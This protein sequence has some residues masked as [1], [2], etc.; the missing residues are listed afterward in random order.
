MMRQA[1]TRWILLLA[2]A[3]LAASAMPTL[4]QQDKPAKRIGFLSV[5]S[6]QGREADLNAFRAG[7]TELRWNEG[8]DYVLS[9]RWANGDTSA[10]PRLAAEL[11]AEKSDLLLA[12]S[13]EASRQFAQ[14]TKTLPILFVVAQDPVGSRLVASL[15][16]PGGNVTGLTSLARDLTAKRLQLLAEAVPRLSHVGLLF[17]PANLGSASQAKDI[18]E[19]AARQKIR[20]TLLELRRAEDIDPAFKRSTARGVQAFLIAQG[21]IPNSLATVLSQRIAGTRLPSMSGTARYVELGGLMSYGTSQPG[22]FRRAAGYADRILKGAKPADLPVE[23]PT[24]FE[25]LLNLKTAKAIGIAFPK[26]L[27]AR[28]DRVIE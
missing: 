6:P 17:D 7:M 27:L 26:S 10:L 22:N 16:R 18:G 2:A 9:T 3:A 20:V 5:A 11:I 8:R 25:L 24:H 21:G 14:L 19:I 4:A 1:M 12:V 28:A 23:Q 15:Q 13:D